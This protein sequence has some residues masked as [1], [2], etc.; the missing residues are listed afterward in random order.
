MVKEIRDR[1]GASTR[2]L[3]IVRA[4]RPIEFHGSWDI[5]SFNRFHAAF[6]EWIHISAQPVDGLPETSYIVS[7]ITDAFNQLYSVYDKIGVYHGEYGY[8]EKV[9]PER[10]THD[11][12]DADVIIISH[13]FSADGLCSHEK[14]READKLGIP[15]FIDCAFFG[16]CSGISFDFSTYKNIHSVAFSL[17]KT[18]GTGWQRVG[19]LYTKDKYPVSVYGEWQYPLTSCASHHYDLIK[20]IGPD[21]MYRKYRLQQEE[22]CGIIGVVPSATVIFGLDYSDQYKHLRRGDVNRLCI[23]KEFKVESV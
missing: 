6:D 3:D 13:P 19:L 5:D 23:S 4:A 12:K 2:K 22:I 11:L 15:I 17:S 10:V 9:Y 21:D 16:I 14:I 8:H 7:G 20:R 18:F 1:V